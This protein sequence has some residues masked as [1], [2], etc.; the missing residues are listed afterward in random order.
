MGRQNRP[1]LP[2]DFLC[3][4]QSAFALPGILKR[5]LFNL[6]AKLSKLFPYACSNAAVEFRVS[7]VWR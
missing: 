4:R 1:K 3:F 5:T 6:R 7:F 2:R